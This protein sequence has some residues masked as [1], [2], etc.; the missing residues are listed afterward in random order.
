M[1]LCRFLIQGKKHR[2][3][4][5]NTDGKLKK[6]GALALFG[7]ALFNKTLFIYGGTA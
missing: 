1:V 7:G 3:A 4:G 6:S 2:L 5:L